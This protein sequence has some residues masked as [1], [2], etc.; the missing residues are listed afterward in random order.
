MSTPGELVGIGRFAAMT[1]LTV[2]ALR[3]YDE[4]GLLIPAFVDP[5]SGYRWYAPG[6]GLCAAMIRR[7]RAVDVPI[8]D[9]RALLDAAGDGDRLRAL[10]EIQ[11]ERIAAAAAAATV[12]QDEL[13]SIYKELLSMNTRTQT[14][15][16]AGPIAAVRVFVRDLAAA[17]LF[18]GERLG[19]R[20]LSVASSWAVFDAGGVQLIVEI[21][22]PTE[23]PDHPLDYGESLIGRFTGV[24]FSVSDATDACNA[25]AG[26]GV[27]VVAAAERQPWG[28]TLAY[29]ADPDGNVLTLVQY[30]A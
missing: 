17:R 22:E 16:R 6:Q 3:H 10:V 24:S 12:A 25:F 19:L 9:V 23:D 27:R 18:Y 13:V 20:E 28:G 30:P 26:M 14:S 4:V 11:E 1:G 5:A 21:A 2:V 29:I 15:P 8:G 7:L